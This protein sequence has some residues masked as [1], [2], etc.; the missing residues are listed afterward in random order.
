[1]LGLVAES[2]D[3]SINKSPKKK[4]QKKTKK[5]A[6]NMKNVGNG[7][8]CYEDIP[9][10]LSK[11]SHSC[12][13]FL[14]GYSKL[15]SRNFTLVFPRR[16]L[17]GFQEECSSLAQISSNFSSVSTWCFDMNLFMSDNDLL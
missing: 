7:P 9:L 8:Y 17:G 6:H 4:Q 1:M 15:E 16:R 2:T 5:H 3:K 14:L 11:S 12:V 10:H 13:K